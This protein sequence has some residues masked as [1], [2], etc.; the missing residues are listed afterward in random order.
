MWRMGW[1][2][3]SQD[4]PAEWDARTAEDLGDIYSVISAVA[5][6]RCQCL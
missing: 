4:F 5:A 3:R 1:A 6:R 2:G